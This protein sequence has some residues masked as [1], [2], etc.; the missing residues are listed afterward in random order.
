MP[1]ERLD[2]MDGKTWGEFASQDQVV[3]DGR[4][5][6]NKAAAGRKTPDQADEDFFFFGFVDV[7]LL[8][9]CTLLVEKLIL[10]D[11]YAVIKGVD[12]AGHG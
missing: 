1:C 5:N 8:V 6:I 3:A 4:A 12:G 10:I 7:A 9:T 2:A 11:A